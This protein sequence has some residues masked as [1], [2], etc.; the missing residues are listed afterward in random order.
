MK[1]VLFSRV[2]HGVHYQFMYQ[3]IKSADYIYPYKYLSVPAWACV[4]VQEMHLHNVRLSVN[5]VLLAKHDSTT[6]MIVFNGAK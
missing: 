1:R 6:T 5:K 3:V 4:C 2:G